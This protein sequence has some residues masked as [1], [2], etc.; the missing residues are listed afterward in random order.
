MEIIAGNLPNLS[1]DTALQ[2]RETQGI[3]V[4]YTQSLTSRHIIMKL[5]KVKKQSIWKAAKVNVVCTY[6]RTL[7]SLR[8]KWNSDTCYKMD[9]PGRHYAKWNKPGTKGYIL[10]DSFYM[11]CLE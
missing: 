6:G 7:F 9:E 8:K 5:S 1:K 4:W 11:R 10:Y 3:H 2:I